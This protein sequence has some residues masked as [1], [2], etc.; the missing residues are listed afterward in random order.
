MKFPTKWLTYKQRIQADVREALTQH[1]ADDFFDHSFVEAIAGQVKQQEEWLLK[2][3]A[4]QAAVIAFLIVGFVSPDA[5]SSLFSVELKSIQGIREV[6]L[7]VSSTA[8]VF[9]ATLTYSRDA[10]LHVA[11]AVAEGTV[12]SELKHFGVFIIPTAFNVRIYIPREHDRW[13]FGLWHGKAFVIVAAL[14]IVVMVCIAIAASFAVH[15]LSSMT[16][17]SI[18]PLDVGPQWH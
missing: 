8:A 11:S 4:L 15:W 3:F 14:L 2:L 6:L 13:Q 18:H 7:A 17:G 16:F 1:G 9:M 10:A 12:A 5:K